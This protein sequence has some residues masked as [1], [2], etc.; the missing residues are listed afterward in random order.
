MDP[1]SA[2]LPD[3]QLITLAVLL[4]LLAGLASMT[5]AALATVS[6]AR[7]AELAREGKRGAGALAAVASDVV[8]Y[9]N[10]LLLL[11]L[12]CELTAT[13]LVTLVAVDTW[14]VGWRAALVAAGAMTL[15]SFVVV[16]VAPRTL[17]RQHAYAVGRATAPLVRWLGRVLNPLAKLL[18]L[19]GNAVTPGK[20][21][22]E[23]PFG[24]QVEL[25]ELVDLAEQRGVV[26]HGER[27]MIHSVFTLGD[28]IARE[29]MVPRTDMV[30]IEAPKTLQ[31]ALYLFLRSGFSR[32]PVIG[33]SVDDVLGVLYLKD[34]IRRTQNGDP[35]ATSQAVAEAMRPANF[36]PE[37]KPVDDLLSEMQAARNHLVIVVDEYGGTAGLVTIEDILE[38]IVGEIT[39]EYDVERPPIEHLDDGAVRVAA[40]LPIE[41]LGDVFGVELPADEVE[42]VG[43]LLAQTLG[44]VPIP[45]AKAEVRG[46]HL[47]AEGTTGRRNRIDSVL[48]RRI[49]PE[50]GAAQ[51]DENVA[52]NE[53]RQPAD[54]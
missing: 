47:T 44:R 20:G 32:I 35:A 16:G 51:D 19:I 48:V 10:L 34:V 30:W 1:A 31:Q 33:E 28:T 2:G 4:V 21:F 41:D 45:G 13:T 6:Q 17:G 54:A 50:P 12:L 26:E 49:R 42:T 36:V 3:L 8:R 25:R 15:V 38:E 40:R 23:G 7:A 52:E 39:D 9:V 46:L 27:E 37:S 24:S 22:P 11:R 53:E 18:I 29:V 14:E 43:G 5:D